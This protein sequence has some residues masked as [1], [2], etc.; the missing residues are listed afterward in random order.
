MAEN[1]TLNQLG[2]TVSIPQSPSDAILET[3]PNPHYDTN[4]VVRL[5]CPEFTSLCPITSQPDFAKFTIDY[6]PDKKLV[7]SKSLKLFM[8]SFRNHG[9]FHEDCP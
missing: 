8:S 3:V 7:E 4:Y 1:N 6:V 2:Q 9:A 5:T